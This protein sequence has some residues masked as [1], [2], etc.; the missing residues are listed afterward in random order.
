MLFPIR[1]LWKYTFQFMPCYLHK[2]SKWCTSTKAFACVFIHYSTIKIYCKKMKKSY[3]TVKLCCIYETQKSKVFFQRI[4][5][6]ENFN[7]FKF[8]KVTF[9]ITYNR[10]HTTLAAVSLHIHNRKQSLAFW[11]ISLITPVKLCLFRFVFDFTFQTN[12]H[13]YVYIQ[14]IFYQHSISIL[15]S[16]M[17]WY[18]KIKTCNDLV[19]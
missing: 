5:K 8:L 9:S 6:K 17:Q 3:Y 4:F 19:A 14:L 18:L 1:W 10:Y 15:S 12:N 11:Y 7:F 13:S 16:E 2:P